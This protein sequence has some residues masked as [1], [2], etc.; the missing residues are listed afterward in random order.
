MFDPQFYLPSSQKPKLLAYPFFPESV[1]GGFKTSTFGAHAIEVARQCFDFQIGLG[2]RRVVVPTRFIDQLYSDYVERQRTFTVDAFLEVAGDTPLALTLPVTAAMIEDRAFRTRL[3]NWTTS[4]PTVD[5]VYLLYQHAR[6]TKQV[7]DAAF[8]RSAHDFCAEVQG[9]G[10][11]LTVGYTNL[12]CLLFS[13]LDGIELTVGA[14]ENTRMFSVDKFLVSEDERRGPK[15][16][17]YLP[18]LLNWVQFGDAQ[19]IRQKSPKV[20][21]AAYSE[22]DHAE[23]ALSQA[24]EPTFNQPP[25]YKHYFQLMHGEFSLLS[26]MTRGQRIGHLRDRVERARRLY[27]QLAQDNVYLERHG[28]GTHLPSWSDYLSGLSA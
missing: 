26:D 20:W 14:F 21:R 5:H 15:A 18:G 9:T 28:Q 17:I 13:P 3:L 25:L 4:Y 19:Q 16:R 1:G 6:D 7:A 12:E 24:I 10:L 27:E 22:T 23:Q 11:T 2:F 8:L